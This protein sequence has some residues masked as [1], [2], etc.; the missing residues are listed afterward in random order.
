[1]STDPRDLISRS[2]MSRLQVLVVAITLCLNAL[3]G[4]DVL[5]I[6]YASPGI[7][8]EW[9][10]D[11][12]A[13]GI[14]LSM[15][16][17]GMAF[18][19]IL[20]GGVADRIGR[21]RTTLGCLVLMAAGMFMVTTVRG[22]VDLSIWR[23][24]TG[25]G[26]GGTLAAIT[27][28]A[29]EFSNDRRRHLNVSLMGI[30]YPIGAALGGSV[31][32]QA[33]QAYD[34]RAVF[35]FGAAVTAALVPVVFFGMPESVHWLARR[36][37]PGALDVLNRT[38]RRMG[39]PAATTLP[40]VSSDVR[41]WSLADIF[42]RGLAA[43]TV[44]VTLAY[45]LHFTTFYFIA[46]WIPK[47][48]VDLG[49]PD[50]SAAGVLVWTSVGGAVGGAVFGFLTLKYS[51]KTLTVGV[52][53]LSMIMVTVFGRTPAD[54]PR[55]SAICAVAGFCTNAGIV[56][57]YAI[58]AQ[59]F[60]THVRAFGTGFVVGVG[61]GGAMLAPIVAGFL[62]AA[63]YSLPAVAFMMALGSLVAAGVLL[64][65]RL[66]GGR[67]AAGG[68]APGVGAAPAPAPTRAQS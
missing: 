50:S 45:F 68:V 63:G 53:V 62:F 59:A 16:L 58:I 12:A 36:Q 42:A 27:A 19:S 28:V 3:D 57:L 41:T 10:I 37:P 4:F 7:A 40:P 31:V 2:P 32:V 21:R 51:V 38:L 8:A 56:G 66:E 26:I 1:M 52:L 65:L 14:V 55:L 15:E 22:I 34:W 25:V 39:H 64:R 35:Y 17:V 29:A 11:R 33:L 61:R 18:G 48:V 49:F 43:S 13:L 60:P 47:I 46:K 23:I 54:L 5:S 24:V 6:S 20:L 67:P 9:G 30:G 44:I